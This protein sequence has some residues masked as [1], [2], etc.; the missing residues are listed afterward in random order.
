ML[1]LAINTASSKT[2]IALLERK[3]DKLKI[4]SEKSWAAKNDEAEKIM[5]EIAKL[6]VKSKK[7]YAEI[8][9]I[10]VIKGPGSFT[11]LRVGVT[12][13]NTISYLTKAK[14][15]AVNTFEYWHAVSKFPV[16][17]YAGSGG[18]YF[19]QSATSPVKIID[20]TELKEFLQ[21]KKIRK[22]SGDITKDQKAFLEN[23]EFSQTKESFAEVMKML[24]SKKLKSVKT[25]VPFYVKEPGITQSKKA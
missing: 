1:L 3:L 22:V 5:P 13:A 20:L 12:V 21:K 24:L 7:T 23:I 18:V 10:I 17:V 4:L 8:Q 16:L 15:F 14:L 25:V 6:L 19:S 9:Q 11:G 2:S